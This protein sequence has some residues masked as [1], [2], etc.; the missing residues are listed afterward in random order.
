M[1]VDTGF[2]YSSGAGITD[3]GSLVVDRSR[4]VI[5][6]S[7]PVLSPEDSV[8][9]RFSGVLE[10]LGVEYVVVAGYV[11]ILFGRSRR[12]EDIDFVV[13][14][15]TEERFV[16]LCREAAGEGFILMQGDIR[17]ED[18]LRNVYREYLLRG[19]SVRF[20]FG[21]AVFPNIEFKLASTYI[22]RYALSRSYTAIINGEHRLRVSP[23]ELQIAY[24]LYM[25]SDKD[26]GDA[27][28]LYTVLK[29]VIDRGE[30]D[31]WCRALRVDCGILEG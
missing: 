22:H 19:Y 27:V 31:Y 26:L 15:I 9:L 18:S 3:D 24:K 8:A 29:N 7:K 17:S 21:E 5:L 12:T 10:R 25:A 16:E 6:L 1:N 20:M 28:F 2:R 23:P 13:E 11:A 14:P 30:L 4:R